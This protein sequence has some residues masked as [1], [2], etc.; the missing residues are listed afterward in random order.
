MHGVGL[1]ASPC[2]TSAGLLMLVGVNVCMRVTMANHH[3]RKHHCPC[4]PSPS[5]LAALTGCAAHTSS[6]MWPQTWS[7]PAGGSSCPQRL[8][9]QQFILVDARLVHASSGPPLVQI[10]SQRQAIPV[11]HTHTYTG[12]MR[13]YVATFSVQN[14]IFFYSKNFHQKTAPHRSAA[15][16]QCLT[17]KR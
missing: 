8:D 7:L 14:G 10:E 13:P 16:N 12:P 5:H 2:A 15:L 9:H 11:F 4:V 17:D 6:P 1:A 3:Q